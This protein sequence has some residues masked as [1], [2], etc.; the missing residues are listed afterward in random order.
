MSIRIPLVLSIIASTAL[1]TAAQK[2]GAK[3]IKF[4]N[5]PDCIE[6]SNKAGTVAVLGHH[7]G[8]RVLSYKQDGK[9]SLFLNPNEAEWT[10]GGKKK[11]SSA[12]RFDIGPEYLIPKRTELWSGEWTAEITGPRSA[13]LTSKPAPDAG[14]RLIRT[15][16]LA[17][18]SSHLACT[19]TM[20][21]TSD[22]PQSWCH[23]GRMFAVHGGIG[24]VPL[25]PQHQRFP[26]GYIMMRGRDE[27]LILPEDP[28]VKRRGDFL[29]I[30]GPPKEPKLGFDTFAG[31]FAY[32][33]PTDL[34][35]VKTYAADPG[36]LYGE[37]AGLTLSIWYPPAK[38]VPAC[39]LEPIGPM[40]T[41]KPGEK[42]S[43]TE[44]WHLIPNKFPKKDE[45]LDLDALAAKVKPMLAP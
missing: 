28:M 12:G 19:Q 44:H 38:W 42:A 17:E 8:G 2:A 29:E 30:L 5:Y 22:G 4:L 33:L 41:V 39:E 6:L 13:R 34:A 24:V 26:S 1:P 40:Q 16:V 45:Q 32:Q 3:R 18:D 14:I 37:I 36:K 25:T 15:F 20:E 10:P 7:V 9:E 21:N 43:F 23:W 27:M 31:W 11:P 35:F